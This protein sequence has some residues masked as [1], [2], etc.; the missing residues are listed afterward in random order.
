MI[1]Y[2]LDDLGWYQFEWLIQSLLKAEYGLGVESWGGHQDYGRDVYFEG[3]LPFPAKHSTSRGPFLFQV[4]FVENANAAGAT[5]D[6]VLLDAVRK[7]TRRIETRIQS[8]KWPELRHYVL[9][10]N[11]SLSARLRTKVKES[12]NAAIPGTQIHSLGGNDICDLLDQ[13]TDLRH[14]F[15]QL[16]SLRDLDTLLQEVVNKEILERSQS[17]IDYARAVI[18]IFVPTA[19]YEKAWKVLKEHHFAVLEGPPEMG[20]TAIAWM[21][22]LTQVTQDWGAYVCD[23]PD[24]FFRCYKAGERQ[25]FVADDAFGRT[26]YDTS[27]GRKWEQQLGPM[28]NRLNQ[29]HWLI[30]TSR[31]YI[32]ERAQ[33]VMDLQ[34]KATQFPDPAAILID[35]SQ[36]SL[37]EKALILYRH[38][39]SAG[40]EEKA[41]N[42]IRHYARSIVESTHFTPERIRRFVTERLPDLV[43]EMT[44]GH[45]GMEEISAEIDMA[46]QNPTDRMRKSFRALPQAH[47]WML[48]SLLEG[49][50]L[51]S[52]SLQRLYETHCP[53]R[54]QKSFIEVLDDLSESFV[55]RKSEI[56]PFI[57]YLEERNEPRTNRLDSSE[58]QRFS[59]RRI[60][61]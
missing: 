31:K 10:T 24:D 20:K 2:R 23:E 41:K 19:A 49:R 35:A 60:G 48:I 59:N 21:I 9:L 13:H 26:E 8:S 4:K 43:S 46:I 12:L 30:W 7:E 18:P 16:L 27:R 51:S 37:E 34:G 14:S 25:V 36:L 17:A 42:I 61:K 6:R 50:S 54:E 53:V 11:A 33:R 15:P 28:L 32:L 44:M 39:R 56:N 52:Q 40:L 5:F 22:T 29:T 58:L 1:R 57:A 45:L 47:K 3:S 38:A 55:K